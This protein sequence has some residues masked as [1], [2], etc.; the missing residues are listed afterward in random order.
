[1][2][3]SH[4]LDVLLRALCLAGVAFAP[5]A[6]VAQGAAVPQPPSAAPSAPLAAPVAPAAVSAAD[7]A[8]P[9]SPQPGT[10]PE[11]V[12]ITAP[13][14][15][16]GVAAIVN[17]F[18]ISE[19]DLD[20]RT[21]LFLATSGVKPTK[22]TLPQIRIHSRE[23]L[24]ARY[25]VGGD[26]LKRGLEVAPL[27]TDDN[28]FIEFVA[29]LQMLAGRGRTSPPKQTIAGMF[30]GRTSGAIPHV[31]L[32]EPD[33]AADFWAGVSEAALQQLMPETPIYSSYS[34]K[35]RPNDRA[36]AVQGTV[37]SMQGQ[38]PQARMLLEDSAKRFPNSPQLLRA[39]T[40][41]CSQDQQWNDARRYAQSWLAQEP[42]NPLALFCLGRSWF[43]L[44][45]TP[46]SLA[47]L[48]RIAPEARAAEEL[49]D[50]PFYLGAL[51][52]QCGN[53]G[54][55]A[56]HFRAFLRREPAHF[57]AR[58]LM[59]DALYRAGQPAEAAAQWERIAQVNTARARQ[60][61]REAEKDWPG[62]RREEAL[63]K[64]EEARRLDPSNTDLVLM[65]AR[66][67]ALS[68]DQDNSSRS[69]SVSPAG[70]S[71]ALSLGPPK[72]LPSG[73]A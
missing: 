9:T 5:M 11:Q 4:R 57:E 32:A 72:H 61:Q 8:N 64:L 68:G 55:A 47:A 10:T 37:L 56:E 45:E 26:E 52:A 58:V 71:G 31:R 46:A 43:Y 48:E 60:L 21:S 6:A 29:P 49:K 54:Q 22:N 20:Q 67:R 69:P 3:V 36:A 17:D 44:K 33:Q 35:L 70:V 66:V 73:G 65:V 40:Q 38:R 53:Y 18:V 13:K 34:L 12:H 1:M 41:V 19:Y 24:L 50:L 16:T 59:A 27:N 25:W 28:M 14:I 2:P 51:Q 63:S 39:L 7:A 42:D 23:D 62:G 15:S 30:D